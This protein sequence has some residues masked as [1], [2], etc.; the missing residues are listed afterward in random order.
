MK[1]ESIVGPQLCADGVSTNPRL[2]RTGEL[3]ATQLHG[4]YFEQSIRGNVYH[5][6]TPNTGV[7]LG[8]AGTTAGFALT[9]PANSGKLA[10][11]IRVH[12]GLVS[13]TYTLG[14]IMHGVNTAT[15][16]N[17][18]TGTAIVPIPGL[19]GS[20]HTPNAKPFTA[21]TLPSAQTPLAPF[22]VK[23]LTST[24]SMNNLVDDIDGRIVLYPGATWSLYVIGADTTPLEMVSVCWEEVIL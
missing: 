13:G 20:G 18:V 6:C 4:R 22:C 17:A 1:I 9:N 7:A 12:L 24:A 2:G 5:A 14:T 19:I 3:I 15:N 11:L 23:N 10:S 8:V 21:A 16:A